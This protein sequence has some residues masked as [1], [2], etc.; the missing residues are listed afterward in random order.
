MKQGSNEYF[1]LFIRIFEFNIR[2]FR[3]LI[4]LNKLPILAFSFKISKI[5]KNKNWVEI[6]EYHVLVRVCTQVGQ[7]NWIFLDFFL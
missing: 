4:L 6:T 7:L 2:I 1:R 5:S 3:I